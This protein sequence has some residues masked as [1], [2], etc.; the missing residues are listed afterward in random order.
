MISRLCETNSENF[1]SGRNTE[2]TPTFWPIYSAMTN[3]M[4]K[5][6]VQCY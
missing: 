3:W 1:L 2:F 4:E 5:L 6:Y